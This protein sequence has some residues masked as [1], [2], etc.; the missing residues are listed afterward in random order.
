MKK[1]ILLSISLLFVACSDNTK[2]DSNKEVVKQV[3]K[4]EEVK[5]VVANKEEVKQVIIKKEV[6]PVAETVHVATKTAQEIYMVCAACH[7][8][9]A[10]KQA[11][12]KSQVIKGWDVDKTVAALNGY[13]DGSYGGTMKNLMKAQV[14]KLSDEDIKKVSEYISSL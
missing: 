12:G 9:H 5:Q 4:T 14:S 1:T 3:V 2:T 8:K 10:E 7:G 6:V 13:K 11:M